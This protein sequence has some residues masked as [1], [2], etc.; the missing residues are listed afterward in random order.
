MHLKVLF[1]SL[2]QFF[3][4]QNKFLQL[5][6]DFMTSDVNLWHCY[7][8]DF[9]NYKLS[10]VSL[11]HRNQ[12]TQSEFAYS[13]LS[14][15]FRYLD[16]FDAT[17]RIAELH[18]TYQLQVAKMVTILRPLSECKVS[19][20][21]LMY[22]CRYMW[23]GS[24]FLQ[25]VQPAKSMPEEQMSLSLLSNFLIGTL[26]RSMLRAMGQPVQ[27]SSSSP[28]PMEEWFWAYRYDI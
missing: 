8:K 6:L 26:V 13:I 9:V 19:H 11:D 20:Y 17:H 3:F 10:L 18:I 14:T 24:S 23:M 16:E 28:H 15:H 22:L 12:P 2:L 27:D 25:H 5:V 7:F 21:S 4:M 1:T